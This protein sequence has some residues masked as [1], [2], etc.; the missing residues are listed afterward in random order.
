MRIESGSLEGQESGEGFFQLRCSWEVRP[1]C[2]RERVPTLVISPA[3]EAIPATTVAGA[4]VR[5]RTS[6][7]DGQ[8]TSLKGLPIQACNCPLS[9]FAIAEFDKTEPSWRPSHLVADHHS[10]SYLK[11]RLGYKFA[12][13]RI[14]GAMG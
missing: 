8:G 11:A 9:V 12:E 3:A 6:F 10:G 4:R 2:L 1:A 5:A 13:C 14:G 7:I